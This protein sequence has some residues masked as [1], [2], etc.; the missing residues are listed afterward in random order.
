MERGMEGQMERPYFIG[1]FCVP[2]GVQL[3]ILLLFMGFE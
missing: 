2:S 1:P 3:N